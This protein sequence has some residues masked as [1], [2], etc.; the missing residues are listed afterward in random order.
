M[1]RLKKHYKQ[2]SRVSQVVLAAVLLGIVVVAGVFSW[3]ISSSNDVS[4][5]QKEEEIVDTVSVDIENNEQIISSEENDETKELFDSELL[6]NTLDSWASK[7]PGT[8][9][10]VLMDDNGNPV[11]SLEKDRVY[12]AASIYKLYVAYEGYKQLDNGEVDGSELYVNGSTREQCLDLM[13]R[14][15]DSPCAEKLWLE[16]GKTDL[17]ETLKEYGINNT[18]MVNIRTTAYDSA[19]ML[20]RIAKGEG[21]SAD[22]QKSFLESMKTQIYRDAL[23]KGFSSEVVVYNKIG[24]RELVEYH[25]TA[26]VEFKDG[27]RLI[28][29]VL[30]ENVGTRNI[31]SLGSA[32]E[33]A[34]LQD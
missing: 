25:D 11:A 32:I 8:A 24:F 20:S 18:S 7:T 21:L 12:F 34:V 5:S 13:I 9:S 6:Q 16:L 30:T 23:N 33:A 27:R 2:G 28:V 22:S 10:V 1:V 3:A 17:N 14:E 15:S 31:A 19:Q 4:V 26:I 29:S